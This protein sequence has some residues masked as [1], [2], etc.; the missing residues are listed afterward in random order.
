MMRAVRDQVLSELIRDIKELS[1]SFLKTISLFPDSA[2]KIPFL[3]Q[4]KKTNLKHNLTLSVCT[5]PL[6]F[7]LFSPKPTQLYT[8]HFTS[9]AEARCPEL[10][11]AKIL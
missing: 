2:H 4:K 11:R 1:K 5:P 7:I 3:L 10:T 9:K 8:P 6:K